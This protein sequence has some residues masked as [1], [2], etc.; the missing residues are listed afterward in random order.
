MA[1]ILGIFTAIIL[2]VAAFIAAKNNAAFETEIANR[3]TEEASLAKSQERLKAAL[4]VLKAL[5]IERADIDAQFA[6]KTEEETALKESNDKI[7]AEIETK[8]E[9]I[10]ANTR[11]LDEIREKTAKIGNI[12]DLAPKMKSMRTELEELTQS[13]SD[14]EA[15]LANLTA[16]DAATAADA[17]RRK[18][19]LETFS[20]GESLPTLKTSIRSIYPTWGFVT[21][22][23][24]N[25]AGVTSNSTLEIVRDG[26]TIAK[27]LV[28][29]VESRS[30]S[31]SI[32]PDSLAQDV[33]L[34]V[35]DRVVAASKKAAN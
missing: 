10:S 28:T 25:N 17:Q 31:A 9:Q 2:A 35:G 22:N 30:A 13:I 34:M 24:G 33:T 18:E 4:A 5:P 14:N 1:N 29:S 19:Q 11:K 26:E 6:T 7:K 20:R 32:I 12:R 23:A 27:L 8:T 16:Q 3:A 21:L 15:T